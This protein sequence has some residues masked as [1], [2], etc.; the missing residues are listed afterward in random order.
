MVLQWLWRG[1]GWTASLATSAVLTQLPSKVSAPISSLLIPSISDDQ[2]CYTSNGHFLKLKYGM[3]YYSLLD[4]I[5]ESD[6]EKAKRENNK[7]GKL[8]GTREDVDDII[9]DKI[10]FEES[11]EKILEQIPM[12]SPEELHGKGG[13]PPLVIFMHGFNLFS[14]VWDSFAKLL[15][16]RG[17]RVL[18]FDFYGHGHSAIPD[19]NY[20]SDILCEQ[21]EELLDRLGLL[22][23][24]KVPEVYVVGHS[25]GGLIASEFTAKHTDIVTKLILLNSVGL[26]VN[27]RKY[28]IPGAVHL[29]LLL[30][31][32]IHW[33]DSTLLRIGQIVGTHSK[34]LGLTHH[35]VV[36]AAQVLS[37][38]KSGE[39]DSSIEE[40]DEGYLPP[41]IS[42][43]SSDDEENQSMI[44]SPISQH[45]KF[46]LF[47]ILFSA[48]SMLKDNLVHKQKT[49]EERIESVGRM[50]R[51][52]SFLVKAW[53]YQCS[54]SVERG[55]VWLSLVRNLPLLD[56]GR[57]E[58]FQKISKEETPILLIWGNEDSILPPSLVDDFQECLS[59]VKVEMLD[60]D[61]GVFLQRPNK[62]FSLMYKF[63]SNDS[64]SPS[65]KRKLSD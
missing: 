28:I 61:H 19:V 4:P 13:K 60:G 15:A 20:T 41:L 24:A 57:Y 6:P 22:D 42:D 52:M 30:L 25:M 9:A 64:N 23:D 33:F 65:K 7:P 16:K 14:F 31:R 63:I 37:E 3:T 47:G 1:A 58:T 27:T 44:V 62:I 53:M 17:Y 54:L 38:E 10:E 49:T 11:A 21:V 2:S 56:A 29:S 8:S 59:N 26:P 43:N 34:L 51:G 48:A 5:T 55:K 46:S 45:S 40:D 35:D 12:A 18:T 39:Y 50:Y 32:R 36:S